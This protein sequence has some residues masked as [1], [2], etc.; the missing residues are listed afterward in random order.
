MLGSRQLLS[1]AGSRDERI[2]TIA[3]CQRGYVSRRQLLAAGISSNEIARA[4]A[5]G[6]LRPVHRGVYAVGH[7]APV[8]LGPETAA[9]LALRDGAALSH[10]T[11]AALWDLWRYDDADADADAVVEVTVPRS[12]AAASLRGVRVHRAN[13]LTPADLRIR[14]GLPVTS[15][16]RALLDV[17]V[18]LTGRELELAFDR[19]IVD[20]VVTPAE[21]AELVARAGGHKGRGRLAELTATRRSVAVTRSEAEE[22]LLALIRQAQLPLPAV[23]ARVAGYEVDFWWRRE[24]FVVEVDGFRFHSTRRAFEHDRRKDAAL[25]AAGVDTMRVTWRQLAFEPYAVI[26][27]IAAALARWRGP[28]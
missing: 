12:P 10:R 22:R 24:R 3:G 20:R 2:A 28:G 16:A 25:L 9:L 14:R 23:N 7:E 19:G 18:G 11:A 13:H 17:A 27:R 6:R 21:I 26:A 4:M 5:G 8:P 1:V 15:P